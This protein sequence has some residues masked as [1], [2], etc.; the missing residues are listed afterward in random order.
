M[1][2][3]IQRYLYTILF[4]AIGYGAYAAVNVLYFLDKGLNFQSISIL[5]ILLNLLILICEI[6]TGFLADKIKPINAVVIG[7]LIII[8]SRILLLADFSYGLE[9]SMIFYGIGL[10]LISG[11]TNAVL[12]GLK[13]SFKGSTE[14]LFSLNVIYRSTGA[15]LGGMGAYYLFKQNSQYPWIYSALAYTISAA[16]LFYYR[17]D[18]LFE[19]KEK[20]QVHSILPLITKLSRQSFFWASVF[21]ASSSLAPFLLWQHLFKQFPY[22]LEYGYLMLQIAMLSAGKVVRIVTFTEKQRVRLML[23]N[24]TAMILMPLFTSS[25]WILLLLLA[26]HVFCVGLLS[27]FFSANFHDNIKQ[28]T[29]S[30]S[31]SIM[32]AFDSLFS[33][34]LLYLIGY[35]MDQ[36]L[37]LLAF[38]ISCLSGAVALACFLRSRKKLNPQAVSS[39]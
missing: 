24:I 12:V 5:F 21:Y 29:R 11:A 34:P 38:G 15:I 4:S 9:C 10:S 14:K 27:I 28:E 32:S 7:L 2:I 23:I 39:Q 18:Y 1:P 35:F 33:L 19:N 36:K 17:K 31:E 37:S 13:S 26:T 3:Q 16:I 25:M 8:A 30:T 6:P 22:G 20:L